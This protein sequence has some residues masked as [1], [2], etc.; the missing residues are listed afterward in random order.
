MPWPM[1]IMRLIIAFGVGCAALLLLELFVFKDWKEEDEKL[2]A[3]GCHCPKKWFF[4]KATSP[5]CPVHGK[6]FTTEEHEAWNGHKYVTF[7]TQSTERVPVCKDCL[8]THIQENYEM[9]Y[10]MRVAGMENDKEWP[11][12][13][14]ICE[15]SA[16]CAMVPKNLIDD[17]VEGKLFHFSWS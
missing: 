9:F 11:K 10:Y 6:T 1:M 4:F 17:W 15:R 16:L 3:Q 7:P 8:E 5:E 12:G 13:C 14:V 2:K